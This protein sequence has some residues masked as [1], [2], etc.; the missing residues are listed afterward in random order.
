MRRRRERSTDAVTIAATAYILVSKRV[1]TFALVTYSG[2]Q[3]APPA[4]IAITSCRGRDNFLR[5]ITP[6]SFTS[7]FSCTQAINHRKRRCSRCQMSSEWSGIHFPSSTYNNIEEDAELIGYSTWEKGDRSQDT[8][9]STNWRRNSVQEEASH[10]DPDL[11]EAHGG[12]P[13]SDESARSHA[14][15]PATYNSVGSAEFVSMVKAQFG[16][17]LSV[18][19]ASRIVLFARQENLDSGEHLRTSR[20]YCEF[21]VTLCCTVWV[22]N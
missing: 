20:W 1:L 7:S 22:S 17:L 13:D 21:N 6:K 10:G 14:P 4:E 12:H 3:R 16:V 5:G 9:H 18:L 11:N 8:L 2:I 19:D 15:A